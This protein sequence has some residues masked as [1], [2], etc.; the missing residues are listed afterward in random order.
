MVV[1]NAIGEVEIIRVEGRRLFVAALLAGC[2]Q[3]RVRVVT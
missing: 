3:D 2:G 1:D